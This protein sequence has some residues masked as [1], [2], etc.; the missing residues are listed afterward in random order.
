MSVSSKLISEITRLINDGW[1]PYNNQPQGYVYEE[2][3]CTQYKKNRPSWFV[4]GDKFLCV[5]C[6]RC[7]S[8]CRPAGFQAPLPI[9][10]PVDAITQSFTLS[11][12]E[13]VVRKATLNMKEVCYCLN[14]SYTKAYTWIQEGKLIALKE[15]PFRVRSIEVKE[16]MEDFD[17]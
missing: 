6:S 5:T 17:E 11:P 15:K 8:L 1:R 16:M 9:N 7:C 14:V 12:A 13:M 10:Y 3:S 4:K 2:L